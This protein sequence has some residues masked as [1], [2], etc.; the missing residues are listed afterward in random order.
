MEPKRFL[1]QYKYDLPEGLIAKK[2]AELRD[3]ARL[4]IYDTKKDEIVFDRFSNLAKYLP[5]GAFRA[6]QTGHQKENALLFFRR[7]HACYLKV[8]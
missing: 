3:A 1:E 7:R 5:A 6:L 8:F 4:L 2:P